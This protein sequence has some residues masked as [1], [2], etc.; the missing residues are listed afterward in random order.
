M[1]RLNAWRK[2]GNIYKRGPLEYWSMGWHIK[3]DDKDSMN[4]VAAH[5][6]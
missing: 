3:Q 4:M 5:H 2:Q 6:G 1:T